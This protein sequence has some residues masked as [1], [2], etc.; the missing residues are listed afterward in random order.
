[1]LSIIMSLKIS[2]PLLNR[3]ETS[4]GSIV[5]SASLMYIVSS[6]ERSEAF[7][8]KVSVVAEEAQLSAVFCWS[9][10]TDALTNISVPFER[11]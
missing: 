11:I 3:L 1:M 7:R 4:T 6:S 2:S 10:N 9:D 5:K 8:H